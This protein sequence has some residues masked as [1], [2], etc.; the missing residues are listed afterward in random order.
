MKKE[1]ENKISALITLF[2]KFYEMVSYGRKH[3]PAFAFQPSHL[4]LISS[5]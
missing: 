2:L 1:K 4:L 5:F 3:A